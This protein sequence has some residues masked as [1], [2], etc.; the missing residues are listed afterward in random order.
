MAETTASFV[1]AHELGHYFLH[2]RFNR[3]FMDLHTCLE[4]GRFENEA[5]KFAAQLLFGQPPLYQE[6]ITAWEMANI[7]NV[8]VCNVDARLIELGIYY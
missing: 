2:G 4:V 3:I 6:P 8:A 5:D 1:C 7:L